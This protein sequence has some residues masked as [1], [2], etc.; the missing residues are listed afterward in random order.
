MYFIWIVLATAQLDMIPGIQ[1]AYV[2]WDMQE[3]WLSWKST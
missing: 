2:Q 1:Y 3:M